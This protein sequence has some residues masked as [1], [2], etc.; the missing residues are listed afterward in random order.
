VGAS[1]RPSRPLGVEEL[2]DV[3]ARFMD[4]VGIP[5]ATVL[6]HSVGAQVALALADRHPARVRRVVLVGPAGDPRSRSVAAQALLLV[7]TAIFEPT[8]LIRIVISDFLRAGPL[9]CLLTLRHA[10]RDCPERRLAGLASPVLIIR[11]A[12]DPIATLRW[13]RELV[14]LGPPGSRLVVVPRA[15]HGVHFGAAEAVASALRTFV[16]ACAAPAREAGGPPRNHLPDMVATSI[17]TA[18]AAQG[19]LGQEPPSNAVVLFDGKGL[20]AWMGVGE[21]APRWRVDRGALE[22]VPGSGDL[23][24][25]RAFS[26]LQLHLE[27]WFPDVPDA[28]GQARANSGVFLQGRYEVQLLDS[29]A[30]EATDDGCGAIYRQVSPMWNACRKPETWQGLDVAFRASRVDAN[31]H[32]TERPRVSVFVNGLLV[33]NNVALSAP[34]EGALDRHEA[35][36]GPLRLQDHGTPVRFRNIWVVLAGG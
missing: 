19:L 31:G 36:P 2:A 7:L 33:L 9:R 22:V 23:F 13:T 20:D 24:T 4:A 29:F 11:G 15:A 27:F 21:A 1:S 3:L 26:D 18:A 25:R 16:G 17:G 10:R 8:A 28:V 5:V 34:T 32:I 35:R 6:G 14:A 30:M 12:R